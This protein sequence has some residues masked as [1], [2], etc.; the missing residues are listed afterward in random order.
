MVNRCESIVSTSCFGENEKDNSTDTEEM[1]NFSGHE[2]DHHADSSAD[3]VSLIDNVIEQWRRSS[4]CYI[5]FGNIKLS[6]EDLFTSLVH[7]SSLLP[8]VVSYFM[9]I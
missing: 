6:V 9:S 2:F 4:H 5:S 1:D 8:P 3:I 7:E